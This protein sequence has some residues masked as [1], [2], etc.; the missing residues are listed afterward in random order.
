VCVGSLC[1]CVSVCACVPDPLVLWFVR[2]QLLIS[3]LLVTNQ[4]LISH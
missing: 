2:P 3:Q 1:V 4:S